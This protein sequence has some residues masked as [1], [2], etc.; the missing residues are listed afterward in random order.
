MG[1]FSAPF[2]IVELILVFQIVAFEVEHCQMFYKSN[3]EQF[4]DFIV[5]NVKLLKLL[6]SLDALNVF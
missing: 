3:I 2:K 6:K 4:I 5:A 1:K